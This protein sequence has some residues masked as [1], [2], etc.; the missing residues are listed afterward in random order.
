MRSEKN[1]GKETGRRPE[2]GQL[3]AEPNLTSYYVLRASPLRLLLHLL[4]SEHCCD[5]ILDE[6]LT[7][8]EPL[9]CAFNVHVPS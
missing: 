6:F 7:V 5:S 1:Q 8:S 4:D 2:A 3:H 9:S